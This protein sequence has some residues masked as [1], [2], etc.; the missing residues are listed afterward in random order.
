MTLDVL[1]ATHKPEGIR[2]VV[3][4]NLPVIDGVRYIVSW[5][6]HEDAPVPDELSRRDDVV[7]TRLDQKGLSNNRNNAIESSTADVYLIADDDIRYTP[8]QLTAVREVFE[9]NPELDYATFMY[10]GADKIYP[11]V[12][13]D[14]RRRLPKG[15]YQSSIEIA[16]RRRGLAARLR[17]HPAFGLG[18]P[19]L[20][21]AEDEMFLLTARRLKLKCRFF[22]IV[23]TNHKGATTGQSAVSDPLV[24]RAWGA[25]MQFAYPL[26]FPARVALKAW[27]M[28]RSGQA[29]FLPALKE[30]AHGVYI[31]MTMVNNPW[32]EARR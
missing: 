8:E 28:S 20:H 19:W 30:L 31:G 9:R 27:R 32:E 13:T 3:G 25:Y 16:V 10:E 4:M 11:T 5:Q 26:T 6:L 17:F 14:L 7:V 1:I 24:L 29:Q 23:I 12:E 21:A 18:S 22:P 2:R 15:F